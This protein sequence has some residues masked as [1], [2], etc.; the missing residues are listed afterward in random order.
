MPKMQLGTWKQRYLKAPPTTT[1]EMKRCKRKKLL[2]T[3]E[4]SLVSFCFSFI[5]G[6][7][8]ESWELRSFFEDIVGDQEGMREEVFRGAEYV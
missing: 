1:L 5:E 7:Q 6:S 2:E 4:K 3:K 8:C